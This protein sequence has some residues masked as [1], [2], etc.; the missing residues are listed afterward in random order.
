[1]RLEVVTGVTMNNTVLWNVTPCSLVDVYQC[2][3]GIRYVVP[4]FLP[5]YTL[6]H[7]R[8]QFYSTHMIFLLERSK[9][10]FL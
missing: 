4:Q 3:E 7:K 5:D 9:F 2:F 1:M 6:S 8:R 10:F